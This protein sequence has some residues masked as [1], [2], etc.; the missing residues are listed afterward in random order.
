M[1]ILIVLYGVISLFIF[2][3][4]FFDAGLNKNVYSEFKLTIGMIL[5]PAYLIGYATYKIVSFQ[6][7]F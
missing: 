6:V 1:E 7:K 2:L 4:G 3:N 5:F